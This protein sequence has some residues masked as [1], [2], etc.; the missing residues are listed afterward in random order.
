[1]PFDP[2]L[3][4]RLKRSMPAADGLA[5]SRLFGGC[6]YFLHGNMCCGV[7]REHYLFRLGLEGMASQRQAAPRGRTGARSMSV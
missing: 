4:E 3:A 7:H 6:G 2:N 1:M 5:E